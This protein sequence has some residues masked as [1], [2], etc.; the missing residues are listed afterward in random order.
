MLL[1]FCGI[2]KAAELPTPGAGSV[3][4]GFIWVGGCAGAVT[5]MRC[6]RIEYPISGLAIVVYGEMLF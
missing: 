2:T 5:D 6:L 1:K 3:A 4:K